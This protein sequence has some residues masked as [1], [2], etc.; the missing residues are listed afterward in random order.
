M[1]VKPDEFLSIITNN[2][3]VFEAPGARKIIDIKALKNMRGMQ[4]GGLNMK[5][6]DLPKNSETYN[7]NYN[8]YK[9]K[10]EISEELYGFFRVTNGYVP[11]F[12]PK[13]S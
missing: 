1:F 7:S 2:D 5:I 12:K 13:N 4:K 8:T 6:S 10:I 3:V 9:E 11:L